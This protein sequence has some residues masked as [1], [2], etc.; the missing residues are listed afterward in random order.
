MPFHK[1]LLEKRKNLIECGINPYPYSFE[2]SCPIEK[3][4]SEEADFLDKEVSIPGRVTA[5]RIQGK[6]SFV[7]IEDFEGQIQIYFK[8]DLI[9]ETSWKIVKQLDLGDIIGVR[10]KVFRTRTNELTISAEEVQMLA[11][12]TVPVPIC[13]KTEEKTFYQL[14]DPEIKYRERYIHWITEPQARQKM[15][16]R[17]RII[18]EVRKF[19]ESNGFLE[20]TTPT[21]EMIYGGAEATPFETNVKALSN[22]KVFL[23]IS[24]E[25]SLKRFIVGG[26]PRVFTI[27]QNFRNEGIDR[28]HNPE[29]T[30]ME[31]YE[32]YTDYEFQM[33]RF[34]ELVFTVAVN[35]TGSGKITYQGREVDLTPPWRRLTMVDAIKEVN[36]IDVESMGDDAI[37]EF[38]KQR[39]IELQ[40]PFSSGLSIEE[41]FKA[42]CEEKL[43]QPTFIMDH[44]AE[45]SPL[46]KSKR[47]KPGFVERFEPFIVGMEMGNAYSELTD[48]VEQH[49]RLCRQKE[50]HASKK[51]ASDHPVN[52]MDLDFVKALGC[53]MPPTGGVG[54]GIDRLVML[55]TDSH[56]IREIIAFPLMKPKQKH[57]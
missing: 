46:T 34:E 48:P 7:N 39:D 13:K 44:P 32:A 15:V 25:L 54:L 26:F 28:S 4:R 42:T 51:D 16:M 2:Q 10:G 27:C 47:G 30:M 45:T 53:G 38:A 29:F 43:I 19:M 41:I 3:I 20:V 31:W 18:S 23:R 50:A 56:S 57:E 6:V 36:G 52:P 12:T 24:P 21:L 11:K 17:A 35:T 49:E 9:D 55:L 22:Q 8:K 5:Q 1:E 40:E 14:S 33:K 37:K